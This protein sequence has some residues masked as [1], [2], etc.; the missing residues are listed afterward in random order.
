MNMQLISRKKLRDIASPHFYHKRSSTLQFVQN[1]LQVVSFLKTPAP[2]TKSLQGMKKMRSAKTTKAALV[3]GAGPSADLLNTSKVYDFVDDIFVINGFNNLKI[4]NELAPSYYGLSDPAHFGKLENRQLDERSEILSYVKLSGATLIL[5]HT[6]FNSEIFDTHEKLFFDDRELTFFS[7]SISPLRPRGYGS[8]TI[9]KM[10]AVACHFGYEK[11]YILGVDNTNFLNY[12]GRIDNRLTDIGQNTAA[13]EPHF[14]STLIQEF[15]HEFTS[16][17]AG[18][19]QSYAH[20]FG[21]LFK[22]PR[23]II[24]NLDEE[25]LVDAFPKV[26]NHP[27]VKNR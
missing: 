20:L 26:R 25:S 13:R 8:T 27:L 5:P 22:F 18:R 14:K 24:L 1:F 23:S 19:M 6:A 16:G 3:L 2:A 7:N 9:Y 21:D 15:E 10:L 4:A 17:I 12:R 11:I